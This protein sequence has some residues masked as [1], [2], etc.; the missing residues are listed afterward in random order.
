MWLWMVLM[1]QCLVVAFDVSLLVGGGYLG[2]V[3]D[4]LFFYGGVWSWSCCSCQ[5]CWC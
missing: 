1:C 5:W 3:F 4:M 2:V